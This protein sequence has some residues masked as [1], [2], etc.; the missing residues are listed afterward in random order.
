MKNVRPRKDKVLDTG[1]GRC[2]MVSQSLVEENAIWAKSKLV[3]LVVLLNK[4]CRNKS[5]NSY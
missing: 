1:A 4:S 5:T 2:E 3:K